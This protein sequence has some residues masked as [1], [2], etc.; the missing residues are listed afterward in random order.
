LSPDWLVVEEIK[1]EVFFASSRTEAAQSN[2]RAPYEKGVTSSEWEQAFE[3]LMG[4]GGERFG[5]AV[6]RWSLDKKS[7]SNSPS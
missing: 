1:D 2:P 6:A 3:H 5:G 7:I 4:G